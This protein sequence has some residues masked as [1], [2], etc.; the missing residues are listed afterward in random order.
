MPIPTQ[1]PTAT[2]LKTL[3][4]LVSA[5]GEAKARQILG[6]HREVLAR[7]VAGFPVRTGTVYQVR[8]RLAELSASKDF[9]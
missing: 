7:I 4:Q 3:R 9:R 6:I 2:E 5:C 8:A 1:T